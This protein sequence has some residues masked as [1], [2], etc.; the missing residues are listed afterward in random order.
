MNILII[1]DVHGRTFWRYAVNVIN[2]YDKVI[3][4]GDYLDPYPQENISFEKA[5]SELSEI[6]AFHNKYPDKVITLLGNHDLHYLFNDVIPCWRFNAMYSKQANELLNKLDLKIIN[7]I[8]NYLFSHAGI[9]NDWLKDYKISIEDLEKKPISSLISKLTAVGIKRGGRAKCGS[10][11]W[12]D[13]EEFMLSD[14]NKDYYQI[15]GHTQL[16]TDP[17]IFSDRLLLR[18][19]S[20]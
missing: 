19:S 7:I 3:F 2:D 16:R 12:C 18:N 1:P 6:I 9:T 14:C 5:L 8:D 4:L 13:I 11:I 10:C 20:I 17:L 15:F